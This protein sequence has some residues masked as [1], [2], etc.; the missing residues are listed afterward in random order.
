ML[1]ALS[2][3]WFWQLSARLSLLWEEAFSIFG[4]AVAV[5]CYVDVVELIG[6]PKIENQESLLF[7]WLEFELIICIF[8]GVR[9]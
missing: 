7:L 5:Y 3:I 6:D 8:M 9:T 4:N 2:F 1:Y